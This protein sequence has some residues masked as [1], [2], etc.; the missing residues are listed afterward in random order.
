MASLLSRFVSQSDFSSYDD[1]IANFKVSYPENFN[2]AYDVVDV[3]AE[4]QPNKRALV[5]C[6]DN[7]GDECFTFADMRNYSN[8]VANAFRRLGI[9]KGDTVM[10]IS[11]GRYEF[12]FC[13]LALHKLGAVAIPATHLM[14][15]GDIV[16]RLR[17]AEIKMVVSVDSDFLLEQ[18]DAAQ[19]V[20]GDYLKTKVCL[21]SGHRE[22]WLNFNNEIEHESEAF[23]RVETHVKERMFLYFTSGT[24]GHPKMVQHNFA[25]PLGHITT[26][27]Y[28]QCV[29]DDGL[30]Y[31][32]SDTGWAKA[33]WGK[34][35]G[36]W[37]A[38]SAVFAHDYDR[39]QIT[40]TLRRIADY[41]VTT[42][43]A[44]PT[45]Y[46]LIIRQ[47]I[48]KYDLSALQHCA[49]AGEALEP[50]VFQRFFE[51]TGLKMFEGYGQT[52]LTLTVGTFPWMEP[53]PGSIGKPSVGYDLRLL[54]LNDEEVPQGE[55]GEIAIYTGNGLPLGMFEGYYRDT[56]L[57]DRVWYNDFYRTGDVARM[58]EDGYIWYVGRS[59]DLI[60]S[61]GYRIGPYEVE[62]VLIK[63][64]SVQE[65]AVTGVPDK[66]RG[67]LIKATV[68][69]AEGFLPSKKL[70]LELREFV[71]S[72]T[73]SYKCP[74]V[75][76]F[77]KELPKTISGKIR[78]VALREKDQQQD[79][80]PVDGN[81]AG[82]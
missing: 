64:P 36:Q 40:T 13:L 72:V 10:L 11:K 69:L 45:V 21:S 53:K 38:G 15:R 28:W 27:K 65:C 52:E 48:S 57:T 2:F 54:D 66:K 73:S 9:G 4:E 78:R 34:I 44:P 58:D 67:Q 25:Y 59:D 31:T 29:V 60:K 42:F 24:T 43:C 76:E 5:W 70:E 17:E 71:K 80:P 47:D 19:E 12:W 8:R 51:M 16:Y 46:R 56:E 82:A 37:I 35:Y 81:I 63:H 68:I 3:Y 30:H 33:V 14:T 39:F 22:G 18:V 50:E 55:E 1:F 74:R 6:D 23:E 32:V 26:A 62:S 75:I 7:G 41:K 77:V 61:A 79:H 20:F 49:S